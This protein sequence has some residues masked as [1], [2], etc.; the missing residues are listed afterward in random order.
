MHCLQTFGQMS[1]VRNTLLE[2]QG[3]A[4]GTV[5]LADKHRTFMEVAKAIAKV[6]Q[7]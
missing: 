5:M 3:T 2:L 7:S 6:R 4:S 1:Y